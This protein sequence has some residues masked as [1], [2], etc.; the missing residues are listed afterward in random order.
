MRLTILINSPERTANPHFALVWLD[1]R[2]KRWSRESHQGVD[3]PTWGEIQ[4]SDGQIVLCAPAS[5]R[6]LCTI[7]GLI[8]TRR[9]EVSAT[10]GQVIWPSSVLQ[11]QTQTPGYWRLQAVDRESICAA[12]ALFAG[13]RE[14]RSRRH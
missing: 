12:D 6:P 5:D 11:A 7:S 1:T 13:H 8:V 9:Q 10:H 2:Q 14:L 4:E 3:L